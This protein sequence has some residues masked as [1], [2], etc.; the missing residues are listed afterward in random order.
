MTTNNVILTNVEA[1]SRIKKILI[2]Y[3]ILWIILAILVITVGDE[4]LTRL[5]NPGAGVEESLWTSFVIFYTDVT[6]LILMLGSMIFGLVSLAIPK[7]DKYRKMIVEAS[8]ASFFCFWGVEPMK[9]LVGRARPFQPGSPLEGQVSIYNQ[10]TDSGSMPSGHVAYTGA[11]VLPYA[12]R[13]KKNIISILL[14]LYTV[15]M[16]YTRVYLGVH[17]VS[18]VLVGSM[19]A[20]FSSVMSALLVGKLYEKKNI[21]RKQ[22]AIL[23]VAGTIIGLLMQVGKVALTP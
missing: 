15:G 18:D 4:E 19:I 13:I 20:V 11:A 22:E 7:L 21:G 9:D 12:I 3:G 23:I 17:W 2:G 10:T 14:C 16:M 5:I 1:N 8:F 6:F